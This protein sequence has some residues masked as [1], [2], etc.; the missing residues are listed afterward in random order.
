[1]LLVGFGALAAA[2]AAVVLPI[3]LYY[4][5]VDCK[6]SN[7]ATAFT[8]CCT[9]TLALLLAFLVPID[10]MLASSMGSGSLR[11]QADSDGAPAPSVAEA[12]AAAHA[13]LL[14]RMYAFL[15][16]AVFICC[17]LLTPAAIFYSNESNRRRV[18]SQRSSASLIFAS[19]LLYGIRCMQ[20]GAQDVD[21]YD[22]LPC[23]TC[24][25]ALKRTGCY[26]VGLA[27]V[28]WI[29][30]GAFGLAAVPLAWLRRGPSTHQ[31]QQQ[32]Q[33]EITAL[34]EQQRRIQSKY[35]GNLHAMGAKDREVLERLR[36]Q[37]RLCSEKH[38]QL[39]EA[40]QG[41]MSTYSL[42]CRLPLHFRRLV[43]VGVLLLLVL[44]LLS[45]ATALLW[46]LKHSTCGWRCGF[47]APFSEGPLTPAD[48]MLLF[49]SSYPPADLWLV[50]CWLL[51]LL[52]G[53]LYGLLELLL[54]Y[55][56][57]HKG[58]RELQ[59]HM[60]VKSFGSSPQVLLLLSALLANHIL[61]AA[62]CIFTA[63]PQYASFGNQM[64]T[65]HNGS[66]AISCSLHA[67]AAGTSCRLTIFAAAL[68]RVAFA[69]DWN[70]AAAA[71]PTLAA[72]LYCGNW[73]FLACVLGCLAYGAFFRLSPSHLSNALGPQ[74][75]S[76]ASDDLDDLAVLDEST[77]LIAV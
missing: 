37:Q 59:Q 1:M 38:Y 72:L 31:K 60:K 4:H 36:I 46:R 25:V 15:G 11:A 8:F 12:A 64:F 7:A 66:D 6:K 13:K 16:F 55:S 18:S 20:G 47:A 27:Q 62:L 61:A 10:I 41:P 70:G 65:P 53:G 33:Q 26:V 57:E 22:A 56:D 73:L 51:L 24:F 49:L 44:M 54:R 63:A 28:V 76:A 9:L 14:Q 32:V 75:P 5:F 48:A 67:A 40:E 42:L 50:C 68:S 17:F 74:H 3:L 21:E 71:T 19:P 23:E 77:R 35:A 45:L 30:F 39:Q 34:R 43:G 69:I 29:F 52:F 58:A 2:S